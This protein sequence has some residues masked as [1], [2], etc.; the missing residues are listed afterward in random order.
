MS[1]LARGL[2]WGGMTI[3]LLTFCPS[4]WAHPG[5]AHPHP[6]GWLEGITHP[7]FGLDHLL[8][9]LASG[10][11]AVRMEQPRGLWL[12]PMAF[13]SLMA[14]G[15]G[16]A[17]VGVPLP[18]SAGLIPLSVIVLGL[19]VAAAPSI[20]LW[21]GTLLVGLFALFHGHGHFA[22]AEI[23]GSLSFLLGLTATTLLLHALAIGAGMGAKYLHAPLLVRLAGAAAAACVV[24]GIVI[25]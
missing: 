15:A 4:V 2:T 16:L 25:A 8:A 6:G 19:V 21:L 20:P 5:H 23:G 13:S 1:R 7:L 12:V 17:A 9:M 18:G 3:C 24:L 10:L 11:L 22:T 14:L